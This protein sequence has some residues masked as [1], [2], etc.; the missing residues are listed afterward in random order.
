MQISK[1]KKYQYFF[2]L[3]L[4]IYTIFNGGNYNLLIQINFILLTLL[5]FFCLRDKNYKAHLNFFYKKNK[6]FILI[7]IIF[8]FIT[9]CYFYKSPLSL[10]IKFFR[11]FVISIF[12]FSLFKPFSGLSIIDFQ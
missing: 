2:F 8:I 4:T 11:K 12:G 3:I 1:N 10:F 6:F 9:C 5:Y 7:Y